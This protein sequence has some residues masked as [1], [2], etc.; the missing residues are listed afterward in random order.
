MSKLTLRIFFVFFTFSSL[1][2]ANPLQIG[3]TMPTLTLED[4]FEKKHTLDP[5]EIK[6]YIFSAQRDT[7]EWMNQ[8]LQTKK[9]DFLQTNSAVYI[10]DISGMPSFVTS[11]FALPKMQKYPYTLMLL[12]D[13]NTLFPVKE[14]NLTIILVENN[15]VKSIHY[16]SN[17]QEIQKF[18][19]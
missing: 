8:F 3:D 7:S 19:L 17:Q 10:S 12:H 4:Q 2:F 6:T 13:E 14:D 9:T 1:L 18:F 11:L 16:I 15:Q 5:K